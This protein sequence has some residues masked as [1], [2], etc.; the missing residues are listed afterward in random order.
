MG[1]YEALHNRRPDYNKMDDY[2]FYR[3]ALW[4]SMVAV[5]PDDLTGGLILWQGQIKAG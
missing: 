4:E 3:F 2:W 1:G 5:F